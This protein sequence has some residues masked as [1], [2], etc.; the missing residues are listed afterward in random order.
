[1]SVLGAVPRLVKSF[2]I[3]PRDFIRGGEAS[4]QVRHILKYI[5]FSEDMLR[6][7][8]VC[9]F[10]SEMNVVMYGGPGTLLLIADEDMITMEMRDSGPGIEDI[11]TAMKEGF[12]TSTDEYRELGFGAGMGLPNIKN[13][14]DHFE[15]HSKKGE[16]TYLKMCI[17]GDGSSDSSGEK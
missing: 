16:G 9:A 11:E 7:A 13:N 1:M 6:R 8:S 14:A 4:I 10:E 3:K 17:R 15:I 5:G 12:S 2:E